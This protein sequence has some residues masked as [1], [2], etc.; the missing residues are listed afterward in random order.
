MNVSLEPLES[1]VSVSLDDGLCVDL[2]VE[3]PV[4]ARRPS[5]EFEETV[6]RVRQTIL[7]HS[8][9]WTPIHW[10]PAVRPDM[11]VHP[12]LSK[13]FDM[14]WSAHTTRE[15]L[16]LTAFATT[17]DM[18]VRN[19]EAL[20]V[21][22]RALDTSAKQ[23]LKRLA[24]GN[25]AYMHA[26]WK[27]K[28][29]STLKTAQD[30]LHTTESNPEILLELY[31][32]KHLKAI[33]C[34]SDGADLAALRLVAPTFQR[35]QEVLQKQWK[36]E[37]ELHAATLAGKL[38]KEGIAIPLPRADKIETVKTTPVS[39]SKEW[40]DMLRACH[41]DFAL[42]VQV[43]D[44]VDSALEDSLSN[45]TEIAHAALEITQKEDESFRAAKLL[46]NSSIGN[47]DSTL[48]HIEKELARAYNQTTDYKRHL[49]SM[50]SSIETNLDKQRDVLYKSALAML[51]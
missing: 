32:Q 5:E 11:S 48:A 10:T 40:V 21:Y 3:S 19:T 44:A 1:N 30:E 6:A 31:A 43:L 50:R 13:L 14:A 26:E 35:T 7:K 38:G 24:D 45:A 27:T 37:M 42:R 4:Q 23:L 46:V 33:E 36:V 22:A 47:V 8:P 39:N 9:K 12:V 25:M 18:K 29:A 2:R 34:D 49:S 28:W 51:K 16:I 15:E 41:L 20:S 17:L